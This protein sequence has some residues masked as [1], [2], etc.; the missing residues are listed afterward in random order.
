MSSVA[1]NK[2]IF[3]MT[4]TTTATGIDAVV[5][6]VVTTVVEA[7]NR[8]DMKAYSALFTEDA[9]FVNVVGM[10][11]RGRP[12]I[13]AVH[14]DLHRTIFRNSNLRAVSTTVRSVSDEVA[15]AHIA[16]EMTGAEGMP[17]WNVPELRKGMMSLVLVRT[18]DRWLITAAQ[19]TDAVPLELPK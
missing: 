8:H 19:N 2:E 12:Q 13:E 5:S 14:I 11:L 16:W 15:V 17:G 18:G 1:Q 4:N 6:A 3:T 10:H 7:W 9:D